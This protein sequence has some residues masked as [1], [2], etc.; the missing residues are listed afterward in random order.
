MWPNLQFHVDLVIFTEET[1]NGKLHFLSRG[2]LIRALH[3]SFCFFVHFFCFVF[4]LLRILC[5]YVA[6]CNRFPPKR[7]HFQH[8]FETYTYHW[9]KLHFLCHLSNFIFEC[10]CFVYKD[11][12]Y[13]LGLQMSAFLELSLATEEK[14]F[15]FNISDSAVN[16][17]FLLWYFRLKG[18]RDYNLTFP[19]TKFL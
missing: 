5:C 13:G 8:L 7:F 19:S 2:C 1:L 17:R 10:K 14:I 3:P 9:R 6:T 11:H 16:F 12:A 15:P 18:S 4:F